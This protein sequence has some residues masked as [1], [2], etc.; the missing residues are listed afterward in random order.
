[1]ERLTKWYGELLRNEALPTRLTSFVIGVVP[2]AWRL[3]WAPLPG[4]WRDACR[5]GCSP[6]CWRRR[7]SCR[8]TALPLLVVSVQ[9]LF[10]WPAER[11]IGTIA[12]AHATLAMAYVTVVVRSRLVGLDPAIAEA[13]MDLGARP[14]TVFFRITLPMIAPG[15]VAG[16]L[17]AFTLSLD[18]LVLASFTSGP[19]ATTLPMAIFSSVRMGVSPQINALATVI[20]VVVA[21]VVLAAGR[22]VFPAGGAD[23]DR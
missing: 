7:W 13:A 19:G 22:L 16:W 1:V 23:R 17:L 12:V 20:V 11:G 3:C 6:R 21:V 2:P 4:C 8:R 18:D 15:V 5:G 14:A 10:G 9:G